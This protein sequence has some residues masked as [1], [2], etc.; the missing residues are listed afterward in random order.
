MTD[1]INYEDLSAEE[2]EARKLYMYEK[3]SKRRRKFVDRV[4]YE[5]WDPFAAPFDPIDIRQDASG[6]TS[7][8]LTHLFVKESGQNKNQEYIDAVNEFNVMLVMNFE[9][10][11]PIYDYCLWYAEHLKKRGITP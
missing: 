2:V 10:V 5:K 8:Q 6:L 7:D 4:G 11:R 9:K 3:M 1:T